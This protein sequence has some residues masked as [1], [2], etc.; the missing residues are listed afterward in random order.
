M[1]GSGP[2][3]LGAGLLA[4]INPCGFAMLPAYLGLLVATPKQGRLSGLFRAVQVTLAMTAGFVV[5]FSL[6]GLVVLPLSSAVEAYMPWASVLL[7]G[8]LVLAGSWLLAGRS[9]PALSIPGVRWAVR[10]TW[11]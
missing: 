3:A 1:G 10:P 9:L 5:V 11:P 7:G 4:A 2:V 6:F 8:V